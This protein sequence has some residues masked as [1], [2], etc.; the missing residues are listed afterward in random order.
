MAKQRGKEGGT[1]RGKSQAKREQC[2]ESNEQLS[3]FQAETPHPLPL[4][5]VPKVLLLTAQ[6]YGA[7]LDGLPKL[8]LACFHPYLAFPSHLAEFLFIPSHIIV[9][10]HRLACLVSLPRFF[11]RIHLC[12]STC[13]QPSQSVCCM[14]SGWASSQTFT[15]C[16]ESF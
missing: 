8:G 3:L 10:L 13:L 5:P 14:F 12:Y 11:L 4:L 6:V 9:P 1:H 7:G 16:Q 15:P 2:S